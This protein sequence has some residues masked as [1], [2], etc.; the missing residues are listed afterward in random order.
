M[1]FL[2]ILR[3]L[4]VILSQILNN[5]DQ[6]TTRFYRWKVCYSQDELAELLR[7]GLEFGLLNEETIIDGT[8]VVLP[9]TDIAKLPAL[10][11]L[12]FDNLSVEYVN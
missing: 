9:M 4:L 12:H 5:F 1:H 6:E 7:M 3:L 2:P 11:E 8:T 10:E